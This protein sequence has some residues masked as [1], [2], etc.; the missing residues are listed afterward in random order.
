LVGESGSGKS[1]LLRAIAG[2]HSPAGGTISYRGRPLAKTFEQRSPGERQAL[3]L[4]FQNPER[5]LN[6][7]RTVAQMLL[8]A[9][10]LFRPALSRT[11]QHSA[12][13]ELLEKVRMSEALLNRYPH[14]L[15]GGEKQRVAIGRALAADPALLLCDEVVSALDV[16]VQAVIMRLI[17]DYVEASGAAAIFVSHDLPVVRMMSSKVL[18]LK[19]GRVCEAGAT[20]DVF[21]RPSQAY[22]SCLVMSLPD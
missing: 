14:Q 18:V 11:K 13:L 22:T 2:L 3:Q 20:A 1:T 17:R 8:D 7:R 15:S 5:S 21:A 12:V 19:D 4:I 10:V 6:P 9:V 16:S